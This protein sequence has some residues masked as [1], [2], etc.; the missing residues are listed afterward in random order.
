MFPRPNPVNVFFRKNFPMQEPAPTN[1]KPNRRPPRKR[2]RTL[3][4][5]A[6]LRTNNPANLT[7]K[8]CGHKKTFGLLPEGFL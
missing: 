5:A 3:F 6:L 7:A 4:Y 1:R 2:R 8:K